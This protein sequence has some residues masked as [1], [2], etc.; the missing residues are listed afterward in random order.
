MRRTFL[1]L[2]LCTAILLSV[3][4]L[5]ASAIASNDED[6]S[7]NSM[8]NLD[9][10][11]TVYRTLSVPTEEGDV[12]WDSITDIS[13]ILPLY[14]TND[15]IIAFYVKFSPSGYAIVN[16]NVYNPVLL[17]FSNGT[18]NELESILS[19]SKISR[20]SENIHICY[21]G[22]SNFFTLDD[23]NAYTSSINDISD[24]G[25]DELFEQVENFF[26]YMSS[27][28]PI[29]HANHEV[30]RNYVIN[31]TR[32]TFNSRSSYS[33]SELKEIFEVYDNL[34]TTNIKQT[35]TIMEATVVKYG[36]TSEFGNIDGVTDHCAATAAFNLVLF[37][38]VFLD[39]PELLINDD[40]ETTFKMIH[41]HIGNGPVIFST[42]NSGLSK[43][44]N[45]MG[46]TYHYSAGT[47][48]SSVKSG[49]AS[50]HMSTILLCGNLTNWH[51]VLAL[52]YREYSDGTKYIRIVDGWET[53][54]MRFI[55]SNNI[56][57][58]YETWIT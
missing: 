51:M 18:Y 20:S 42:Y 22:A 21:G 10:L 52:G 48:Y 43:Y 24:D 3:F 36:T 53:N 6:L 45:A 57:A 28:N 55:A 9:I 2:V 25:N 32:N 17:E 19:A 4:S 8:D 39:R 44:V 7:S 47:G 31:N 1:S 58:N 27:A 13:S 54:T 23:L 34:S 46:K 29:A 37:E 38:S 35:K 26:E 30:L 40:R 41:S 16:N 12:F 15:E 50:N 56:S 49:I 14:D 33:L 11:L 5:P